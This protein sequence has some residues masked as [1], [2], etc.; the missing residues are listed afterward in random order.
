VSLIPLIP[1][2]RRHRAFKADPSFD[3][4]DA[5]FR[6]LAQ[7]ECPVPATLPLPVDVG[8]LMTRGH[9]DVK[10]AHP[11]GAKLGSVMQAF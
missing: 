2:G 4:V 9:K 8:V 10:R 1:V 6:Q 3:A 7:G 5:D 11:R